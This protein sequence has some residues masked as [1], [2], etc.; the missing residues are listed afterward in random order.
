MEGGIGLNVGVE[1][2]EVWCGG[3]GTTLS[4]EYDMVTGAKVLWEK[5][6]LTV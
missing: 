3:E 6:R 5:P 1:W 4:M 2:V